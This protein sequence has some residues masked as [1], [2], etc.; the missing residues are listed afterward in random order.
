MNTKIILLIVVLAGISFAFLKQHNHPAQADSVKKTSSAKVSSTPRQAKA[1]PRSVATASSVCQSSTVAK[2][3]IVSI[4]QQHLWACDGKSI[5]YDSAVITG[6]VQ[7][8]DSTPLGTYQ[9]Y[10]RLTD[11]TLKGCDPTGCWNDAVSYWMPYQQASG[12]TVGFHDA[13]WHQPSDFGNI[14]PA[15]NK[16]SH[17]CVELPLAAAKWLYN[18]SSVGTAVSIQA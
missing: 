11:Q 7:Y 10:S 1:Q 16:G 2:E 3:A 6:M 4:S 15:S 8:D 5:A 9:I 17:G 14:T 13:T 18:W 12:G